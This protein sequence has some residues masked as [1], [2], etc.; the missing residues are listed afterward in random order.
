MTIFRNFCEDMFLYDIFLMTGWLNS[1]CKKK[2][3]VSD[4]FQAHGS[5]LLIRNIYELRSQVGH[6]T[7]WQESD[8]VILRSTEATSFISCQG[9]F[10]VC[11]RISKSSIEYRSSNQLRYLV[12]SECFMIKVPTHTAVGKL[13]S[14]K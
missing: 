9:E 3:P 2:P 14:I 11:L 4:G 7:I 1:K 13:W 6:I 12:V 8:S 5:I 10:I